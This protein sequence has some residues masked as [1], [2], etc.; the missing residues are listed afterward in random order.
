MAVEQFVTNAYSTIV[1]WTYILIVILIVAKIIQFFSG[2]SLLGSGKGN[3]DGDDRSSKSKKDNDLSPEDKEDLKKNGKAGQGL[4][5]ENPGFVQ[6]IVQ[7][8]D[9]NPIPEAKVSIKPANMRK[10]KWIF[11]KKKNWREYGGLTGA[12]GVWPGGGEHEPVG[13]G[14]AI[15]KVSKKH[16]YTIVWFNRG[17]YYQQKYVEIIPDKE[18][19]FVVKMKREG[20]EAEWFEP[21]VLNVEIRG[22]KM[23]VRGIIKDG[24]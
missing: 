16:W 20:K 11:F 21:K 24:R 5:T 9:D 8:S 2:K 7:D 14:S 3:G 6:V 23:K 15:L 17:K 12:D 19:Y 22:D 18:Q 1:S 4:D 13:S 10:R